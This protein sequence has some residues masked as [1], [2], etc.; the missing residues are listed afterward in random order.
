MEVMSKMKG[1]GSELVDLGPSTEMEET[2]G[3]TIR[4]KEKSKKK[5]REKLNFIVYI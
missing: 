1:Q 5:N 3:Q 4:P 2:D